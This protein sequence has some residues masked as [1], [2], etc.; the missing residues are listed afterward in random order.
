[1]KKQIINY[2]NLNSKKIKVFS[3]KYKN[4]KPFPYIIIDNFLEKNFANTILDLI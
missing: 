1:M 2:Q 4:S 3:F